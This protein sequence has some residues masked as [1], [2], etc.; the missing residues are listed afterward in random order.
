MSC[1]GSP[2]IE[3]GSESTLMVSSGLDGFRVRLFCIG[4][5]ALGRMIVS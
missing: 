3:A 4:K 1:V 5:A 2:S